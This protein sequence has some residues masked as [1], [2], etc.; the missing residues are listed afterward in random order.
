MPTSIKHGSVARVGPNQ[1]LPYR[2]F[3][4]GLY[5]SQRLATPT[6]I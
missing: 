3:E 4:G 1:A 5:R 6:R 2:L